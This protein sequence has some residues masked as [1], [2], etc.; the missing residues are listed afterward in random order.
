MVVTK[1]VYMFGMVCVC[2]VRVLFCVCVLCCVICVCR[3]MDGY[4]CGCEKTT[5][6]GDGPLFPL[7]VSRDETQVARLGSKL[8]YLLSHLG[9]SRRYTTYSVR[10]VSP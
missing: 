4:S 8:F 5:L 9:S 7:C 10:V 6:V 3:W 2:A 1:S